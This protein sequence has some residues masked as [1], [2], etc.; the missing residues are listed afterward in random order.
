MRGDAAHLT[1]TMVDINLA[2][3]LVRETEDRTRTRKTEVA[4]C[5]ASRGLGCI[6]RGWV[7]DDGREQLH[8]RCECT[9]APRSPQ[10]DH[11]STEKDLK[12]R[13]TS[14]NDRA[15][16]SAYDYTSGQMVGQNVRGSFSV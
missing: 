1:G 15:M 14:S 16:R 5:V 3:K 6:R 13:Y 2:F 4:L 12:L 8:S 7:D 11:K 10:G 9:L